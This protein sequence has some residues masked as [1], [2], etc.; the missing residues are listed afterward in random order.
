LKGL[1]CA[2]PGPGMEPLPITHDGQEY[3]IS[4]APPKNARSFSD[5]VRR[6]TFAVGTVPRVFQSAK[7]TQFSRAAAKVSLRSLEPIIAQ[8]WI[9]C[10]RSYCDGGLLPVLPPTLRATGSPPR[11]GSLIG[12]RKRQANLNKIQFFV[13]QY[14]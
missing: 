3:N 5:G 12:P 13:L 6:E 9:A 7:T 8:N 2:L 10:G 4:S 1:R 14:Q 11:S